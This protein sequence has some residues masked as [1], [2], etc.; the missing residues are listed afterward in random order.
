MLRVSPPDAGVLFVISGPSGVGK[1]TLLRGVMDAIPGLHFSTSATT[2]PPRPGEVDGRDYHFVTR[3]RFEAMRDA[4]EFLEH[5]VVYD[6][7]YGTPAA[8]VAQIL[9]QGQ[10]IVLDVDVLGAAQVRAN[11][12]QSAHIFVLPPSKRVLAKRL[13]TRG[14]D[15]EVIARRMKLAGDQLRGAA[16]FDYLV[17]NDDLDTA[18]ATLQ[19]IFLAELHRRSRRDAALRRV[20]SEAQQSDAVVKDAS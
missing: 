6:H 4:G 1:S 8:P 7:L 12:P 2:R 18:H 20:L 16:Q 10:S 13:H 9:S 14:E 17:V 3:D 5:A 11:A 19:G 15:T